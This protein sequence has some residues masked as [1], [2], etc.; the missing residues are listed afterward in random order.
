MLH[1]KVSDYGVFLIPQ[2]SAGFEYSGKNQYSAVHNS[3]YKR[4]MKSTGLELEFGI[5]VDTAY[6]YLYTWDYDDGTTTSSNWKGVNP[7]VEFATCSFSN[8]RPKP[9][10]PKTTL[11]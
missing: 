8:Y 3:K 4:F 2:R 11:F 1:M 10:Q 9:K 6:E 7:V 5:G